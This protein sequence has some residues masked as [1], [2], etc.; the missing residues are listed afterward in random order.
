ML[1]ECHTVL[2]S[3]LYATGDYE[4]AAENLRLALEGNGIKI[5]SSKARLRTNV[6]KK[7]FLDRFNRYDLAS[8]RKDR[9]TAHLCVFLCE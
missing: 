9:H 7:M 5:P 4:L 2:G 6:L 3:E 8:P 1:L